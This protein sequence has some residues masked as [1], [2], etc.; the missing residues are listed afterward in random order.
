MTFAGKLACAMAA[1][2]IVGLIL[3]IL[4]VAGVLR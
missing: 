2:G 4:L 3:I 1:C